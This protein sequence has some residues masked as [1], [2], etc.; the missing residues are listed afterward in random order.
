MFVYES[1]R[2]YQRYEGMLLRQTIQVED[3]SLSIV[4]EQVLRLNKQIYSHGD[5]PVMPRGS[6]RAVHAFAP[7][8]STQN[9]ITQYACARDNAV[10]MLAFPEET[11]NV[12]LHLT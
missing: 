5:V 6:I 11:D 2:G 7:A 12:L 3:D 9:P 4:T 8:P 1:N 10:R